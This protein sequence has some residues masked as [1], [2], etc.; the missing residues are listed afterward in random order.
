MTDNPAYPEAGDFWPKHDKVPYQ[1]GDSQGA[2]VPPNPRS[3]I[4]PMKPDD[5][6]PG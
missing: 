6:A 5:D 2:K 1:G 4:P 3:G